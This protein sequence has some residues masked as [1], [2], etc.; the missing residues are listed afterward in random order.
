[1]IGL[2]ASPLR[3]VDTLAL[4]GKDF[5]PSADHPVGYRGDGNG[6]FPGATPVAE[7]RDGNVKRV[8]L[9]NQGWNAPTW[10]YVPA[11]TRSHNIVWR[12][13][14]ASW[15]NGQPIV[16]GD[17]VFTYGEPDFLYCFD[18]HT[19]KLLWDRSVNPWAL[20]GLPAATATTC[21]A[22][23]EVLR[24]L[25]CV[26]QMSFHF[27]TCGRYLDVPAYEHLA[28]LFIERDLPVIL[29]HLKTID[30]QTDYSV[31][32]QA[33]VEVFRSWFGQKMDAASSDRTW[34]KLTGNR[35]QR[36]LY[37]QVCDRL[38]ELAGDRDLVPYQMPWGNMMGWNMSVPVSDGERVYVQMGQGQIAAFDLDGNQVWAAYTNPYTTQKRLGSSK[39]CY[40]KISPLL[41]DGVL[42]S[43]LPDES[44]LRGF[45]ARTGKQLW[46][47]PVSTDRKSVGSGYNVADHMILR[48]DGK[49]VIVTSKCLIIRPADGKVL[50]E[51]DAESYSGGSPVAG[52]GDFFIKSACG[53]GF[54]GPFYGYR[55][56]LQG[57]AAVA[58]RLW[59]TDPNTLKGDYR[60]RIV[61]P[62][63]AIVLDRFTSVIAN[64]DASVAMQIDKNHDLSAAFCFLA[65]TALYTFKGDTHNN[66]GW[67]W[68]ERPEGGT[69]M[70]FINSYEASDPTSLREI[71][72]TNVLLLSESPRDPGVAPLIPNLW[73]DSNFYNARGGKPAHL[74][75]ADTGLFASGNR[76]FFRS[77]AH[78]YCIGDP[79]VKYDWNPA[80]RDS[81]SGRAAKP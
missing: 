30:P 3:A 66:T 67:S 55:L 23:A 12:V 36:Q 33:S 45:D 48:V 57:D 64:K 35:E 72:S 15:V 80:S 40:H 28:T 25:E 37:M 81:R 31:S 39:C 56:K 58:E 20:A 52:L 26:Y 14:T 41:A 68:G 49:A 9:G 17:R 5:Y 44:R 8:E 38:N 29:A 34:P 1:M 53:D 54:K 27:G 62:T 32:A 21:R 24:T 75:N 79:A 71:S 61:L 78:L 59:V 65:G 63:H 69:S 42:V 10:K 2:M 18:A 22:L 19:G 76:L 74:F 43:N 51:Y 50:G 16:V 47:V 70:M 7:F 60:S 6:W 13:A 73:A 11:D 46:D 77:T 4:G